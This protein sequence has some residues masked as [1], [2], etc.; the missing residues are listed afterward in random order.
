MSACP[1]CGRQLQVDTDGALSCRECQSATQDVQPQKSAAADYLHRFPATALLISINI[2]VFVAMLIGHVSAWWPTSEQLIRWGAD[3]GQ[4]VILAHQWWRIVASAFVHIGAVHLVMNMWALWVLGTLA[5]AVLGTY[6]FLGV[7]FACAI[8]GSLA[9]LYWNPFAISAGASGA[10]MGILGAMLSVLKFAHLPLPKEVLRST[11]RSLVQGAVLTLAIGIFPRIDNAS[12]VGGLVCGLFTG[13]ILSWT[14]RAGYRLQRPLRQI[15]LLVP[16]AAMVPLA[17]AM[18]KH[19]EPWAHYQRAAEALNARRYDQAE[20]EARAALKGLPDRTDVLEILSETLFQEGHDA[21]AGKYL[22]QLIAENPANE[23]A[24]NRLAAI[25]LKE[26]DAIG[27]RDLLMKTLPS[28]QRNAYGEV[29]LGRA[30]QALNQDDAA[31]AHYR[32]AL[33]IN[34]NLYEGELALASL[35]EKHDQPKNAIVLYQKA[36]QISPDNL[37]ALRGLARAYLSAGMSKQAGETIAQIQKVE[38]TGDKTEV[39]GNRGQGTANKQ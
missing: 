27:A 26:D 1:T 22:R 21:E 12:H 18:Q 32:K 38:G 35:Y 25:E 6:L 4:S 9:T 39:T 31:I 15:C 16:F 34:P 2:L 17:F 19:S 13:L 36:L 10:I 8:A 33:Q 7:Y 3:S 11:T 20:K 30:L 14:R 37:E 28:Q 24:V 5:E 23:F 29:Y